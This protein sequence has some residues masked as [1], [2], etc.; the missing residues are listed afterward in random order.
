MEGRRLLTVAVAVWTALWMAGLCAA[1]AGEAPMT[2]PFFAMCTGTR[3]DQHKSFAAQAE[4][5]KQLGYAGTDQLGTEGLPEYLAELD[6]RGLRFFAVYT[7]VN[8][9]PSDAQ[10]EPGLEKAIQDLK[11]RDAFLWLSLISKKHG[12]S[13]PDGDQ[14][15]VDVITRIADMAKP[16]GLRIALYPHTACWLERVEDAV[17]VAQKVNRPDVGVTFNECHWLKVDGKDLRARLELAKPY[18][19]VVTISGADTGGTDWKTLIQTLDRGS[20][21]QGELLSILREL[22]YT[23]PIGLQGYGIGG[24]VHE[25]LRRS[26]EAWRALSASNARAPQPAK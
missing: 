6:K 4:M 2:N 19:F 24:D 17:R 16:N 14:N 23:G 12:V 25:N 15:A 8:I 3:D 20:F 22:K 7:T 11:G 5:L 13:S 10:W 21:N 1:Q 18:L 9:D 26:M